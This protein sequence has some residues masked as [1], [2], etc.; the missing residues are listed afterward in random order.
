MTSFS[1][2]LL[3]SVQVCRDSIRVLFSLIEAMSFCISRSVSF[4]SLRRVSV[5]FPDKIK[6]LWTSFIWVTIP[7][8]WKGKMII[9]REHTFTWSVVSRFDNADIISI[10]HKLLLHFLNKC[11]DLLVWRSCM[12]AEVDVLTWVCGWRT[13]WGASAVTWL[14]RRLTH[15]DIRVENRKL[16]RKSEKTRVI[17]LIECWL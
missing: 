7:N 17:I 14:S 13:D 16:R 9:Y 1:I 4:I 5:Y 6:I 12:E 2:C 11:S 10:V 15:H 3:P 8:K